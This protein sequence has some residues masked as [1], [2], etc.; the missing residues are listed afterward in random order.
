MT[1]DDVMLKAMIGDEAP[2]YEDDKLRVQKI[3][4]EIPTGSKNFV[5]RLQLVVWKNKKT[6]VPDLDI[7]TYSYR[8]N[9][10]LRGVTLPGNQAK[11]LY[12]ALKEFF[13]NR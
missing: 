2:A 13:E 3:L 12:I 10:Y 9:R 11:D 5:K 7:R 8:D 6:D 4:K 1:L